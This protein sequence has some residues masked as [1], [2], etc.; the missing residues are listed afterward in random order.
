MSIKETLTGTINSLLLQDFELLYRQYF[1]V[2][3]QK[4]AYSIEVDALVSKAMTALLSEVEP[5][6]DALVDK[7]T[8]DIQ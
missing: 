4:D 8:E 7:L 5:L 3:L 6:T 2:D 1:E